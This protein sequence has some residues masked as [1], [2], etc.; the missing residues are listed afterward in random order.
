M[1]VNHP[2]PARGVVKALHTHEARLVALR[3]RR[4]REYDALL[5]AALRVLVR[6]GYERTRV[7][8]IMREARIST[9]AFYRFCTGKGDLYLALFDRAN[10]AAMTRLQGSLARQARPRARLEAYI[11]AT[12]DLA[13]RE[14]LRPEVRLFLTAPAELGARYAKEV[15]ACRAGLLAVL[16]EILTAGRASGDFP[17]AEPE[18]DAWVIS[19]ALGTMLERVVLSDDPPPRARVARR[20]RRFCQAALAGE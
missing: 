10:R 20:L 16:T 18:D 12:L 7:E 2:V 14:R 3:A 5:D 19:G 17:T 4:E 15:M 9:R 1:A 8:D 13:Y 11:D 6:R